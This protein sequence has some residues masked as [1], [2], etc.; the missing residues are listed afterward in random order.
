MPSC[1]CGG[2]NT[3]AAV[4]GKAESGAEGCHDDDKLQKL[5]G[6]HER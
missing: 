5:A 4:Y 2:F 6:N 3:S 1:I